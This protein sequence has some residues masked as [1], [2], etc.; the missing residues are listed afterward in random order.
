MVLA[1]ASNKGG[2]GKTTIAA[3]LAIY[4]R[5]LYEELPILLISLDDQG[6]IDRMFSLGAAKQSPNLKH[7]WADR[8]F[9]GVTQMGQ[10]GIH[11]VPSA[12]ALSALKL[13]ARDP[14]TLSRILERSAW[15][16][17]VL[18]DT[19]SDFEELTQNA[20]VAAQRVL[21]PVADWASLAEAER[22]R[23]LETRLG[24]R[25]RIRVVLTLVDRRTK[26]PNG[27]VLADALAGAIAERRLPRYRSALSRSPRVEML[28]SGGASPRSILHH[29]QG[30]AVHREFRELAREAA[31][32]LGLGAVRDAPPAGRRAAADD[33]RRANPW[34]DFWFEKPFNTWRP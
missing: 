33:R 17:L 5:A 26:G 29:A 14:H 6:V 19:K 15:R 30:T 18:L 34:V 1:V 23:E 12:H 21:V 13:R 22:A 32:D 28:N 16:G 4:L 9:T 8:S 25:D 7:A 11:Y 24:L 20:F 3:N 10:Y 27:G 2:V 31:E